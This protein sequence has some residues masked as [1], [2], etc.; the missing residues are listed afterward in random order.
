VKLETR[1]GQVP[2]A[3]AERRRAAPSLD[4]V[5]ASLPVLVPLLVS[6]LGHLSAIDLAYHLRAGSMMLD[7]RALV[8]VDPFT[9]T[10]AGRPWLDQQ[11][12]AQILMAL[13]WRTGGFGAL[14][15]LRAALVASS[16]GIVYRTCRVRG[17]NPRAASLL[18]L[19]GFLISLQTLAMRPQLLALPLFAASLLILAERGTHPRRMWWL[20][21]IAA[22]WANLH[23]SFALAPVLVGLAFAE[24]LGRRDRAQARGT[25]IVGVTVVAATLLSPFGPHV[26]TYAIALS[27]NPTI[28]T[29][30]TEWAPIDLATFAGVAFF[31]SS[32]AI[33]GWLALRG[34]RT[35]WPDLMWLGA[36]FFL[37]LPAAR[38]V[39][40]WGL[41]APVTV[42]GLLTPGASRVPRSAAEAPRSGSPALNVAVLAVLTMACVAALPILRPSGPGALVTEAPQG[43][44]AAAAADL[45]SGARLAVPEPW[46]SWFE[47]ALP[48]DPV[49]VDPRIE[50]F[51][52]SVW[53]D[54]FQVRNAGA[55]WR[56]V[57][58]RWHVDAVVVDARDPASGGLLA[59]DPGWR[60]AYRDADGQLYV[61]RG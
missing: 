16:F 11:W 36:F 18:S 9:F 28:R 25:F 13:T 40:W 19:A 48:R 10:M 21:V 59:N 5:W 42:A 35:P 17:A 46:G 31:A 47:F 6:L 15:I 60:L 22:L 24:D 29:T 39:I 58:D 30:V 20:P 54:Y 14:G 23:G 33:A 61:R 56:E 41:V 45:P 12:G 8:R 50:L 52:R 57:L 2:S 55:G 51:D 4:A 37:T 38:G 44:V 53:H 7:T 26:W 49:L 34:R 3:P 27:T 32:A 1:P 43:I